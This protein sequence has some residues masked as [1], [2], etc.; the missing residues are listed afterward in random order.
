MAIHFGQRFSF[1]SCL[2]QPIFFPEYV[3]TDLA[4]NKLLEESLETA[5]A[6]FVYSPDA[7]PVTEATACQGTEGATA[8]NLSTTE[9]DGPPPQT[10][11]T[12]AFV[13]QE[14]LPRAGGAIDPVQIL[15]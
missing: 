1:F 6:K 12:S 14:F 4:P 11:L 8:I 2:K 3:K 15:F 7:L 13:S 5:G 10:D 9:Q